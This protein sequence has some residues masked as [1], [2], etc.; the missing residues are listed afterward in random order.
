[1]PGGSGAVSEPTKASGLALD[2]TI[3]EATEAQTKARTTE[4]RMLNVQKGDSERMNNG[5]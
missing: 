3:G 4:K 5:R 2:A 1:M